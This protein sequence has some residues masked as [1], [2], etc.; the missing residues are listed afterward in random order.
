MY[1]DA[2]KY[3]PYPV[4]VQSD[5]LLDCAFVACG[6]LQVVVQLFILIMPL[7][8]SPRGRHLDSNYFKHS[9]MGCTSG[10]YYFAIFQAPFELLR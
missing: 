1:L 9:C 3:F 4:F 7:Y 2:S 6:K 8:T 10:K 5:I